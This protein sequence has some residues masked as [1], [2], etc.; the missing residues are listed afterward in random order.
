MKRPLAP[1]L[2]STL[3]CGC[4]AT[5][6]DILDLSQQ[7]DTLAIH[8]HTIQK[9]MSSLQAS[10]ADLN[11]K[12][13]VLHKDV[14]S[15]NENLKDNRETM[16]RLSSK[17]DDLGAAMSTKVGAIDRSLQQKGSEES[18]RIAQLED[19]LKKREAAEAEEKRKAA[20][21]AAKR[22]AEPSSLA[23]SQLYHQ[24]YVQL[25]QGKYDLAV[26]G[27]GLYLEKF[28]KGEVADLATY[29]LGQAQFGQKKW[30]DAAHQ[31]ALV[32][33]RYPKSDLVAAARLRYGQCLLNI[34]GHADEAKRY[35]DS[36]PADF[37]NSPEAK[38][39][40]D[41]LKGLQKSSGKKKP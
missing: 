33:D 34:G 19:Q 14:V 15:L 22:A 3:L 36:I 17:M 27:F 23:P 12:L 4:F 11:E 5:Q 6:R 16:S 39:A 1:L 25:N 28:P 13:E 32:L 41:L 31:F 2:F 37:P 29:Y 26:Q 24:A 9:T 30:G 20:E 10:Q 7:N 8:V 38:K 40:A 18:R 21:E 35:L